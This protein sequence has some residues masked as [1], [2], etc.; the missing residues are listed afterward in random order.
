MKRYLQSVAC[1]LAAFGST[2]AAVIYTE[3]FNGLSTSSLNGRTTTTGGGVWEAASTY[4][5]DGSAGAQGAAWLGYN[6]QNGFVY[7]LTADIDSSSGSSANIFG[8]I[9]FTTASVL[10]STSNLGPLTTNSNAFATW[11]LRNGNGTTIYRGPDIGGAANAS[12]TKTSAQLSIVLDT[13]GATWTYLAYLDGVQRYSVD[14]TGAAFTGFGLYTNGGTVR[15][16]D[17]TF[18]AVAV[19]EP[20]TWALVLGGL[21]F[22]MACRWARKEVSC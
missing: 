21:F 9:S 3:T 7:T 15:F 17:L 12:T 10:D 5:A 22:V 4:K 1:A 11:A 19:P 6:F 8:A 14:Y 20:G 2:Q 16:D 13:T 18:S